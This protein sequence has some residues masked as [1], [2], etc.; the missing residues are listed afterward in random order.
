MQVYIVSLFLIVLL[1]NK[2]KAGLALIISL[3][4]ASIIA[5]FA[6]S[7]IYELPGSIAG[8]AEYKTSQKFTSEV[9]NNKI[10]FFRDRTNKEFMPKYYYQSYTR[11]APYLMGLLLGYMLYNIKL[12]DIKLNIPPVS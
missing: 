5:S 11:I 4:F 8:F 3:I 9:N 6:I 10:N 7:W 2:L 12:K 1:K